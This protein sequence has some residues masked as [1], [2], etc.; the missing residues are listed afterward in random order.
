MEDTAKTL[1]VTSHAAHRG[2]TSRSFLGLLVTQL[3]GACNDNILRWLVIGIGKNHVF[4][5]R[6][7]G[8]STM[9]DA[10]VLSIGLACFVVP[11]LLL[12]APA[13]FVADRFSKR[14]V[15]VICKV[16]EIVIMALAIVVI[17]SESLVALFAVVTLMG[18]QS[19]L[20]GPSKLGSIPEMLPPEKISAANGILGMVTVVSTV[21]GGLGGMMLSDFTG[22]LG[23]ERNAWVSPVALIG[24]A[25][26][27]LLASLLIAPLTPA[28][29]RRTFPYNLFRQ[30]WRDLKTLA[31]SRAML[32]VAGGIALFWT[33]GA[34][35]Q[36]N[37]DQLATDGGLEAQTDRAPMLISLVIGVALGSVLAGIWSDGRVELGILPL[38]AA[39][40]ALSAMLLFTVPLPLDMPG[41]MPWACTLL[42]ALGFSAGLFNVPLAA[43]MQHRSKRESRGS[44]LAASNF[45]A[46]TGMLVMSFSYKVMASPNDVTGE[47]MLSAREIFLITGLLTIPVFV[48]IIVIIPQSAIRF[49]AWLASKTIYRI[50]VFGRDNLPAEGGAL[51]VVNHVS[52]LDGVLLLLASSRPLRVIVYAPYCSKG[53]PKLLGQ[54]F[55]VI[56]IDAGPKSI[57]AALETAKQA[58]RDG[59]LVAIFPEGNITR[60]GQLQ[61]FKGGMFKILEAAPVPVIPVYLDELWGSIFS[62]HGGRFFWKWP[63]HWRYPISIH[64]GPAIERPDD[65]HRVRAAVE[66]LGTKA[67]EQRKTRT[68]I[69]PKAFLR[70]CRKAMFRTKVSDTTGMSLTGG[71]LLLKTLIFRRV[72]LRDVLSAD[73]KHVGILLPSTVAGVLCNAVQ[74]LIGRVAVNLNYTVSAD[75]MN[76]CIGACE[77]KH[78]LTSRKMMEKLDNPQLDAELVYLEDFKDMVTLADKLIAIMQAYLLPVFILDRIFGLGKLQPDDVLTVIFTSGSTGQPKGVMLTYD[79]IGS[80]IAAL[81]QVV[82]LTRDDVVAGILPFFHSFGYTVTLW[83]PLALD[84][85]AAYH[86]NPL[87]AKQVGKLVEKFGATVLLSTATFLRSYLKRVP[88]EQ[89]KTLEVIVA[90]AEKLPVSLIGAF[91][92]KFGMRPVEGYGATE[93]SPLVSV[94]VPASRSL[95]DEQ[96]D[97][98]EGTVGRPVPGVS[99]KIVDPDSGEDLP[100]QQEGMLLVKGPNIMLGYLNQ[101][102]KTAEVMRGG[103]YVTGDIALIDEAGFIKITG[104]L[105]RF[106]KIGGEMVPHIRIEEVLAEIVSDDEEELRAVVTAVPD[107][108]KGERLVIVHTQLEQTPQDICRKLSEAGLPNLWIPSPDSFMQV[109]EIP[110]LGTGKLDLKQL[111]Q[112][113]IERFK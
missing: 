24:V 76:Y 67:H 7:A 98:R 61:P 81:D 57:R 6:Q 37:L 44:I 91:E 78:V 18:S 94:N 112:A 1:A 29:P 60:T 39:G 5:A 75:V 14:R 4:A 50:R 93:T 72:L 113:A 25:I 99:A 54:L 66:Q 90:G 103:W 102:D 56:P 31:A 74:P 46:F 59:E 49:A 101:P 86:A 106:S 19:A 107:A 71:A 100:G 32:R 23:V 105:S 9:S 43:Y 89:F 111:Q 83:T 28:N 69:L 40:M 68:M 30:T 27:G 80:N 21:I 63:R 85:S 3:L 65:V 22:H 48:Y 97:C 96:E 58:L 47:P 2:L 10:D 45:I 38:G 109:E 82:H 108:R 77:I 52:W 12:A 42:L 51:L 11:Y 17:F 36:L 92:E 41:S 79:N 104:R 110:I 70:K 26:A 15:I 62:F 53:L 8:E 33:L 16:A 35:A 87:E 88:A 13:G 20:F 95:S 73:E 64:F 55:G 34:L 84:L